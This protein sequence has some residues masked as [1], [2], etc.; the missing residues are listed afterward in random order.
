MTGQGKSNNHC[1]VQD[2]SMSILALVIFQ[3]CLPRIYSGWFVA[4][5]DLYT[6]FN[7]H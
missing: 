4:A 2:D 7:V 1:W 6:I 5:I 3:P